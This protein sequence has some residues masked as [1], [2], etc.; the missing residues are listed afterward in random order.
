[1]DNVNTIIRIEYDSIHDRFSISDDRNRDKDYAELDLL[2][3]MIHRHYTT[4]NGN[5][6]KRILRQV[7]VQLTEDPE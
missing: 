6:P 2:K 3:E 7:L 4:Y 1:M 5:L